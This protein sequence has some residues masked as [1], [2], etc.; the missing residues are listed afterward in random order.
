MQAVAES[1][2]YNSSEWGAGA[3]AGT[4]CTSSTGVQG[5]AWDGHVLVVQFLLA[6]KVHGLGRGTLGHDAGRV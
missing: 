6:Y 3:G 5:M 2:R 4:C 1:E